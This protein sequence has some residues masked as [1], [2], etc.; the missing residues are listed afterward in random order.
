MPPVLGEGLKLKENDKKKENEY[1]AMVNFG[2]A[3]IAGDSGEDG[4][5][6]RKEKYVRKYEEMLQLKRLNQYPD[7][8]S[9]LEGGCTIDVFKQLIAD[10]IER[11]K[12]QEKTK[13]HVDDPDH[14]TKR[15]M[16]S[17]CFWGR[18]EAMELPDSARLKCKFT[19]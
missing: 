2:A 12:N 15:L 5:F 6:E 8:W 16:H 18:Y 17:A 11:R 14:E 13:F 9:G 7:P 1:K 19:R 10:E 3:Q 4:I